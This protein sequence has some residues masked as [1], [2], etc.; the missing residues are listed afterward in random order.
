MCPWGVLGTSLGVLVGSPELPGGS[1]GRPWG[2]LGFLGDTLG[3][4][5]CSW[6]LLGRL[7]GGS[8]GVL[9]ESLSGPSAPYATHTD[10]SAFYVIRCS[11]VAFWIICCSREAPGNSAQFME[12]SVGR[13]SPNVTHSDVLAHSGASS[14]GAV[15]L[16]GS[17]WVSLGGPL[18]VL[19]GSFWIPC[20]GPMRQTLRTPTFQ[21]VVFFVCFRSSFFSSFRFFIFLFFS[22]TRTRLLRFPRVLAHSSAYSRARF[23][24]TRLGNQRDPMGTSGTLDQVRAQSYLKG[25]TRY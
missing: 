21:R 2:C 5:G 24:S 12:P 9:G 11:C 25:N 8:W 19:R 15:R 16:Q 13:S 18:G 23:G 1:S 17:H 22:Y 6:G 20:G 14:L 3:F 7:V 4:L 10:V